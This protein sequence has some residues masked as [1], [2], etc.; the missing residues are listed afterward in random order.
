MCAA[1]AVL[2]FELLCNNRDS[3]PHFS[4]ACPAILWPNRIWITVD[5]AA[6]YFFFF[7]CGWVVGRQVWTLFPFPVSTPANDTRFPFF[8]NRTYTC[9]MP[10]ELVCAP[11]LLQLA[12]L[13][14]VVNICLAC[15]NSFLHKL[16][17]LHN[18]LN[19]LWDLMTISGLY[20]FRCP[21]LFK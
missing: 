3:K 21:A 8:V 20:L 19:Y 4:A 12:T 16:N 10:A 13:I 5:V 11:H 9:R 7:G 18:L 2:F 15:L 1:F 17:I 6:F 14:W